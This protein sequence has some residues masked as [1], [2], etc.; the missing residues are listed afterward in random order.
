LAWTPAIERKEALRIVGLVM[1]LPKIAEQLKQLTKR[2]EKIEAA[3]D[4]KK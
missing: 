4:D 3:K 2:I 1:R